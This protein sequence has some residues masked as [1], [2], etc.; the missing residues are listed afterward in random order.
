MYQ[1]GLGRWF[2]R[3]NGLVIAIGTV[4]YNCLPFIGWIADI[5]DGHMESY[6][7]N[8]LKFASYAELE[9]FFYKNGYL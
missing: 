3:T 2:L 5:W 8:T 6:T 4:E 9:T 7:C 1:S